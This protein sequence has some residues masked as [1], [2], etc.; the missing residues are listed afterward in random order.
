MMSLAL[1]ILIIF[2]VGTLIFFINSSRSRTGKSGEAVEPGSD[3]R[4]ENVR[5]GGVVG[6]TGVGPEVEDF[7]LLVKARH[8]YDEDGFLWYDL[9]CDRGAETVWIGIEDDDELKVWLSL[10]KLE[11]SEVGL[12]SDSLRAIEEDDEG[13]IIFDDRSFHYN[14]CGRAIYYKNG[15]RSHGEKLRYWDFE[16]KDGVYSIGVERWGEGKY[17]AYH[18]EALR[19][20]QITVYGLSGD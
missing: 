14:D 7:D 18:S 20:S 1:L 9:E 12:T 6:L 2:A 17:V 15:D 16:T 10:K 13:K 5:A 4:I 11:L 3:L 19:T 8:V